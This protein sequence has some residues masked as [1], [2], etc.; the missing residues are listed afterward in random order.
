MRD[1]VL[2]EFRQSCL[3]MAIRARQEHST[4]SDILDAARA[5]EAYVVGSDKVLP[6]HHQPVEV[7]VGRREADVCG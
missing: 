1:H 4:H 3:D 7:Q 6:T 5:F 2:A